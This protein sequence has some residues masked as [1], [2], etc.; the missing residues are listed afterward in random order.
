MNWQKLTRAIGNTLMFL[1]VI[2]IM[3]DP[4][5][6]VLHLKDVLFVLAFGFNIA[7]YKPDLRMVPF[8]FLPFGAII[9]SFI[10]AQMQGN[11]IDNE[12]L[13]GGIKSLAVLILLPW[14]KH[15]DMLRL[16][17]IAGL[18]FSIVSTALFIVA[19][20]DDA[21]Q[22][23]IF[24]YVKSHNDMIMM[25]HRTFLG[26]RFFG[27]YY[28]SLIS[29]L[30]AF[31]YIIYQTANQPKGKIRWIA[32]AAVMFMAF[33]VSGT[34]AT[35]L[36]PFLLI[37]LSVYQQLQKTHYTRY[38]CYP[39]L[40]LVFCMFLFLIF[41]LVSE[42]NEASNVIKYGHLASYATLFSEHPEYL[43]FGQG[44]G[45]SF[46]SIGFHGMTV[47]T[48]WTYLELLRTFGLFSLPILLVMLYPLRRLYVLRQ[49]PIVFSMFVAYCEYL[50]VA[51]TNPLLLN[52][53]G[54]LMLLIMYSYIRR[55]EINH[56]SI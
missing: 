40:A 14:I 47:Q 30:P 33:I 21:A 49:S 6:T 52:S 5:N 24:L 43:I 42:S 15:Y 11:I 29:I 8:V 35:I 20:T 51:G 26:F 28:K 4:T 22:L 45:S 46:Y 23:G 37:G 36:V 9:L 19:S 1:L 50:L 18:I 44:L 31:A 3:L 41:S 38:F 56:E 53:T 25:T 17:M 16:S 39:I 10:S 27:M 2:V 34:R 54:M 13:L 55:I 32:A 12:F 7:F 48:E